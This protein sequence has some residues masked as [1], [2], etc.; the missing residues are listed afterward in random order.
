MIKDI[1]NSTTKQRVGVL[2]KSANG[3][4][5][6]LDGCHRISAAYLKNDHVGREVFVGEGD[7]SDWINK[8]F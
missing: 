7:V 2:I 1:Q 6:I 4:N 3:Y 5:I 8:W